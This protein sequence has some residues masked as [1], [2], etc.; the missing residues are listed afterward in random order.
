MLPSLQTSLVPPVPP[1]VVGPGLGARLG[2]A[3]QPM[4]NAREKITSVRSMSIQYR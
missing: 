2:A 3:L 1:L 4:A